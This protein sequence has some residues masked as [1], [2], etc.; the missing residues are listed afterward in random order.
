MS[1]A[2]DVSSVVSC[3]FPSVWSLGARAVSAACANM[4]T[5][6]RRTRERRMWKWTPDPCAQAPRLVVGRAGKP[7]IVLGIFS[8]LQQHHPQPPDGRST[9]PTPRLVARSVRGEE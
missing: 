2:R 5:V 8:E 6:R 1:P 7:L 9:W 3:F 4:G